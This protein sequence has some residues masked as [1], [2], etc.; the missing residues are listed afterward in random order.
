MNKLLAKSRENSGRTEWLVEKRWGG[1]QVSVEIGAY[2]LLVYAARGLDETED[3]ALPIF[4]GITKQLSE[5]GGFASTQDTVI[6]I[7]ALAKFA[8]FMTVEN[9]NVQIVLAL[10]GVDRFTSKTI[11]N[12]NKNLALID[13]IDIEDSFSEG[14]VKLRFVKNIFRLNI[15]SSFVLFSYD[16]KSV[17][18]LQRNIK[19]LS[20]SKKTDSEQIFD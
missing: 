6:G 9:M 1:E 7:Q 20:V 17:L 13:Q 18:I 16:K 3:E 12:E 15:D 10:D 8:E 2:A 14:I 11:S 5:S 4:R 19:T